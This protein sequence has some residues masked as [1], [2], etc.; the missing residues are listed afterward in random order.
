FL[1]SCLILEITEYSKVDNVKIMYENISKVQ[2]CGIG[3]VIDDFGNG[4]SDLQDLGKYSFDGIKIDKSLVSGT[5]TR[6]DDIIFKNLIATAS[7]LNM[8]IIAEGVET[9]DQMCRLLDMGCVLMQGYY[10]YVP[11]PMLEAKRVFLEKMIISRLKEQN[12]IKAVP[13]K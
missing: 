7:K 11:M 5:H 8:V 1:R 4:Y 9:Y 13:N 10:F 6:A 3:V 12:K 2:Q